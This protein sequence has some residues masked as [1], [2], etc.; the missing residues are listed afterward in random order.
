MNNVLF[1]KAI[2]KVYRSP[3]A[4]ASAFLYLLS[5]RGDLTLS[6]RISIGAIASEMIQAQ[7]SERSDK[8]KAP[9]ALRMSFSV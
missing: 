5:L 7:T 6:Q 8:E 1:T 2:D 9:E 4:E 3:S